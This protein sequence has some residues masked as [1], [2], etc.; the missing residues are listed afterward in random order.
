MINRQTNGRVTS[1]AEILRTAPINACLQELRSAGVALSAANAAITAGLHAQM[2][3]G[4]DVSELL[5][6]V[7]DRMDRAISEASFVITG[8]RCER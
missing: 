8:Q 6:S 7:I 2:L 4:G 5:A 1:C 3:S